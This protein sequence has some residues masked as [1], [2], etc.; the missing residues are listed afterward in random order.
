MWAC[1]AHW[2]TARS[3]AG[4]AQ[5][6]KMIEGAVGNQMKSES[7]WGGQT[8]LAIRLGL[9]AILGRMLDFMQGFRQRGD[10]IGTEEV[11]L[12]YWD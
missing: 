7:K 1:M 8:D 11:E 9:A 4:V 2:E 6:A 12:L 10:I 5:K 3:W